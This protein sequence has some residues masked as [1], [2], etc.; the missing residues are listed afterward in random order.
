MAEENSGGGV[1]EWVVTFGDMMSLLLTFFIML[2]SMSE[3]KQEEKFQAM[4]ESM[5][6]QFG[7]DAVMHSPVPGHAR[8]RNAK[9]A[10][11]ATI[12]RAQRLNLMKGGDKTN[13]PTGDHPRVRIVRP[14][15]RTAIGTVLTFP[16]DAIALSQ[17]QER[18]L[19]LLAGEIGGKPQKIEIRGHTTSSPLPA[20]APYRDHWDMAYRRAKAVSDYLTEHLKIAP[21]RIRIAV[22]G[23]YEPYTLEPNVEEQRKN[24]RVEVYLLDEV[25]DDLNGTPEERSDLFRPAP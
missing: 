25:V 8:P 14:G 9:L 13:A 22:A 23:P 21:Q 20:D 6:R 11:L 17:T 19:Q 2:V 10:S 7:Y 1:P 24:A 3:V 12:G 4:V 16:E 18:D 15:S 5:R